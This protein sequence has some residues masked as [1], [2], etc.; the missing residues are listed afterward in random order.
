MVNHI[1]IKTKVLLNI[2]KKIF[3]QA[4]AWPI[5]KIKKMFNNIIN[6]INYLTFRI[7]IIIIY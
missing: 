7:I 6:I 1:F 2:L 5:T 4:L 3:Y